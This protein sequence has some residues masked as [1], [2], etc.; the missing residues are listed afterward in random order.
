MPMVIQGINHI[1]AGQWFSVMEC[2]ALPDFKNPFPRPGLDVPAFGQHWLNPKLFID[3]GQRIVKLKSK[4]CYIRRS[5]R[6]GIKSIPG[7]SAIACEDQMAAASRSLRCGC[8]FCQ[9]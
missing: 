4:Y 6:S 5:S 1:G 7:R 3:F 9:A 2:D 8:A